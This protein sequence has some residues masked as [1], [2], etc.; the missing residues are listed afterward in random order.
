MLTPPLTNCAKLF[1]LE[2]SP[3]AEV[4]PR[5]AAGTP[6]GDARGLRPASTR[7]RLGT[8]TAGAGQ[9]GAVHRTPGTAP[10]RLSSTVL[11]QAAQH[12][13]EPTHVDD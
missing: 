11:S 1:D 3:V 12:A 7:A 5:V 10:G 9:A 6:G 2:P 13:E 4:Q 8:I